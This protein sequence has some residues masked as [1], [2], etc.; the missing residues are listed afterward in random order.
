MAVEP[1][2]RSDKAIATSGY[3]SNAVAPYIFAQVKDLGGEVG[4]FDRLAAPD[5]LPDLLTLD[6]LP[7][8]LD[9]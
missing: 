7:R 1:L 2:H 4:V 9:Q 5:D 6:D 3:R 8:A